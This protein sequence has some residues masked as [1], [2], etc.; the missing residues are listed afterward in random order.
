MLILSVLP[1]LM[2]QKKKHAYI[3][4]IAYII[5]NLNFP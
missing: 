3:K 4:C 2:P 5:C 1:I